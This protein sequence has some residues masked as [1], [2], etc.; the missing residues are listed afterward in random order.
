MH[1]RFY[2]SYDFHIFNVSLIDIHATF[3]GMII[4][5]S[6]LYS[7]DY[8]VIMD[9]VTI[10]VRCCW[11]VVV[12]DFDGVSIPTEADFL[13]HWV[14]SW[15]EMLTVGSCEPKLAPTYLCSDLIKVRDCYGQNY[16]PAK[17]LGWSPTSHPHPHVTVLGDRAFRKIIMVNEVI[18][19]EP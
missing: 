2:F 19:V 11:M 18:R 10:Y 1:M 8:Y 4:Y 13:S 6:L 17:F 7:G 5:F 14:Q 9:S 12:D 15:E 16:V 3:V